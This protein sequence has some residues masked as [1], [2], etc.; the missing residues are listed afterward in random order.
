MYLLRDDIND[1]TRILQ[2][3]GIICYPTDTI[4]GSGCDAT[5]PE[6]VQRVAALK[7][8]P[9]KSGMVCIVSD[10]DMLKSLTETVHPRLET[11]LSFHTRPLD[12]LYQQVSGLAPAVYGPDGSVAIRLAQDDFTQLLLKAVGKPL[13]ATAACLHN[14]PWPP[15]FGAV[16]SAILGGVDYVVKYRQNDKNMDELPV[17]VK[18]LEDQEELEFV[19]E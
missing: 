9:P 19:R 10:L 8:L 18:L 12:M 6:S 7:A 14:E 11:L 13:L 17:M 1:I 2:Q 3:G 16:S 15:T 4:W 5:N